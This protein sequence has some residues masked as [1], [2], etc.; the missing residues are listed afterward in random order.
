MKYVPTFES[1][2]GSQKLNEGFWGPVIDGFV[3]LLDTG[4]G[5]EKAYDQMKKSRVL[6]GIETD[7][8]GYL[9]RIKVDGKDNKGNKR[10]SINIWDKENVK[11]A[12]ETHQ[13]EHGFPLDRENSSVIRNSSSTAELPWSIYRGDWEKPMKNKAKKWK[14]NDFMP[15][16][17]SGD[18]G[19]GDGADIKWSPVLAAMGAY[20]VDDLVWLGTYFPE[21][22]EKEGKKVKSFDLDSLGDEDPH[23]DVEINIYKWKG[24]LLAEHSDDYQYYGTLCK[25]KDSVKLA[26]LL[27]NDEEIDLGE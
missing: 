15:L 12:E 23:G 9:L 2:I 6:K 4:I 19:L 11:K 7:F 16:V 21:I 5:V 20:Y 13:K 14:V 25:A 17:D 27:E 1:F 22:V 10:T 3:E 8:N 18:Y 24:M 26:K